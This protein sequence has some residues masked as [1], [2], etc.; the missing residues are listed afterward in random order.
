MIVDKLENANQYAGLSE[1]IERAFEILSDKSL[2][3]KED[4]RYEVDG[5]NLFYIVQRY[6]TKTIDKARF[7][8]HEKYI[9]IHLVTNGTELIGHTLLDELEIEKPYDELNDIILYK[10]PDDINTV[11]LCKGTFCVLFPQDKHMP[12]CCV[13]KPG[14]VC[15]I[16]V[17][18]RIKGLALAV[19]EAPENKD[20]FED[21]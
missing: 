7:E 10:A 2:A 19:K 14:E 12:R 11:K 3:E 6:Q 18:V 1:K 21:K 17:K 20:L 8:A 5:D 15:K 4:G 9:D 13:K 16:V